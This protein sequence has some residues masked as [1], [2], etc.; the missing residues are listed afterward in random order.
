MKHCIAVALALTLVV[1]GFFVADAGAFEL[2]TRTETIVWEDVE[3]DVV[4][5]AD[6]FIILYDTSSSMG[7]PYKSTGNTKI[8]VEQEILKQRNENFPQLQINAGLYTFTPRMGSFSFKALKPY[9]EM[10]AYDKAGFAKAIEQLPTKASGPT[11]LQ[12]GL[13]E[14]KK[15]LSGLKGHTVVFVVTDGNFSEVERLDKPKVLARSLARKYDVSFIV[16]SN[17]PTH[18]EEMLLKAVASINERSRVIS[19]DNLYERPEY[20][21]GALFVLKERIVERS[22]SID[23]I[24]GAEMNH[25]LYDYDKADIQ[26]EFVDSLN[27]FGRFLRDNPKSYAVLSGFTDGVGD[28]EYNFGLSRRRAE[29][30]RSFLVDNFNIGEEQIVM[31]WY[32]PAAPAASNATEE[33]RQQNRRVEVVIAGL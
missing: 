23:K 1:A 13:V 26:P 15:I 30:I 6:N 5:L 28:L 7:E 27:A 3:I 16:V 10:K 17:A 12:Q 25:I 4:K 14:L 2:I 11:L 9:Y 19:F 8:Q 31:Q 33:G 18:K 24:V 21:S 29:S 22:V 20:L 32:G